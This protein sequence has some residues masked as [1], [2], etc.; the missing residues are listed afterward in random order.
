MIT[1]GC[2]GC[3]FLKQDDKGKGCALGQLSAVKDGKV[4]APGYCR[5]CRS[6]KWAKKQNE[7]NI[8]TLY[9]NV[10]KENS[11]KFDL[12][13]I[14]DEA[15]NDIADL[16]ETLNSYW[17]IGYTKRIII[18][19]VTGFGDRKNFALQYLNSRKHS[20]PITVDSSV[21]HES[22]DQ[23]E[24]TIRRVSK[25]VTSSFFM[26]IPAGKKLVGL[27]KFAE[28]VESTPSR[29]IHWS[30]PFI[31]GATV[32]I[33]NKLCYGLFITVPYRTLT[34]F[35]NTELFT[36]QL[37]KEE[38]ETEMGLSWLCGDYLLT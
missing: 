29:V 20:I 4:F 2:E 14:F 27:Y 31:L 32:I 18:V 34:K 15:T 25:Q 1:T 8:I 38:I 24:E 12:L 30:F 11:L 19:D 33:P 6:H 3:C 9:G 23:R 26:V 21:I 28:I 35:P 37:R 22:I 16:E 5:L 36:K 10:L 17:Y 7:T 13:V